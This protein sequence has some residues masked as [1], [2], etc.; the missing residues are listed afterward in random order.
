MKLLI[1]SM[2]LLFWCLISLADGKKSEPF[3]GTWMPTKAIIAGEAAPDE[4]LHA[5]KLQVMGDRYKITIQGDVQEGIM[6]FDQS[7][8]PKRLKIVTRESPD[9]VKTDYCI[10]ELKGEE[11]TICSDASGDYPKDFKTVKGS[12]TTIFTYRK[13]K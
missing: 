6:T 12:K 3:D 5:V 10:Y 4:F 2:V 11:W 9:S 1:S 7:K 13:A 8:T